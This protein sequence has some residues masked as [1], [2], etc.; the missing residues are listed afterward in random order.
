MHLVIEKLKELIESSSDKQKQIWEDYANDLCGS[1]GF[2]FGDYKSKDHKC[3]LLDKIVKQ[4]FELKREDGGGGE[5][6]GSKY[7]GVFS[8][9]YQSTIVYV[10]LSGWYASYVGAEVDVY[11]WTEVKPQMIQVRD[12]KEI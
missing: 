4:G 12:W 5:G 3:E 10:K 8:I 6:E 9:K 7:W 2:G 11:D 1:Y